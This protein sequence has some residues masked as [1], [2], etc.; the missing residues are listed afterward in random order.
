MRNVD[1]SLL[2]AELV[3]DITTELSGEDAFDASILPVKVKCA[4]RDVMM[5]RNYSAT[6][7]SDEKIVD[8]LYNYYSTIYNLAVYEYNQ[9]GMNGEETHNENSINRKWVSKDEIL[10]GV[11]AFVGVL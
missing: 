2:E 8:D 7:Y 11:H 4:V 9:I 3:A 10:K 1:T 6:S 5:R